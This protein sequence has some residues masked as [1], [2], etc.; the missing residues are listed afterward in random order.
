M[1]LRLTLPRL[2][3]FLGFFAF[4]T[5]ITAVPATAYAQ[6]DED[7][8]R[9]NTD[10]QKMFHK[11]GR[12]ISNVLLGWVEIPKNIAKEWRRTEPFTGTIVGSV[13][14]IGW[15][16]ARTLSGV[17]EIISFPFPV[18]RNYEPIMYPEF[19]LPSVWGERLPIYQDEFLASES[20]KSAAISNSSNQPTYGQTFNRESA[21]RSY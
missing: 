1:S 17:Y 5:A 10:V 19:V 8:Y 12:G 6:G 9:E 13:K 7:V 11:L 21:A 2:M 16:I 20:G 3:L 4:A 14:G 15:A 18:P